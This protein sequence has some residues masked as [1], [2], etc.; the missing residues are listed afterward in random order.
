MTRLLKS[1]FLISFFLFFYWAFVFAA[2]E[3]TIT[4]YYPSPYG[5]YN[6]LFTDKLG[7]GDNSGDGLFTNADVP[8]NPGEV[9]IDGKVNIGNGAVAPTY[10]LEVGGTVQATAYRVGATAGI[11]RVMTVRDNGGAGDCSITVV[12]GIIT[13]STC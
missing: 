12:N 3:I 2:E 1:I 5:S 10:E 6:A 7:V 11:S 9:W 13:A 4:T 8:I